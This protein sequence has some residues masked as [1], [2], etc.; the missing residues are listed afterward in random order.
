M[1][2]QGECIHK[3]GWTRIEYRVLF[4]VPRIQHVGLG[5]L[6][7]R[8]SR[9]RHLLHLELA[10]T[11]SSFVSRLL[12]TNQP[13]FHFPRLPAL[14]TLVQYCC[15]IIGQHT[16]PLPTSR[17]YATHHT[18]NNQYWQ[19]QYRVKANF[20]QLPRGSSVSGDCGESIPEGAAGTVAESIP[21]GAA[22]TI[23]ESI[24]EGMAG[25]SIPEGA[26]RLSQYWR[27]YCGWVN[28]GG[29]AIPTLPKEH[30][31]VYYPT[32]NGA[33]FSTFRG[34]AAWTRLRAKG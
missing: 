13:F 9:R 6:R 28:S 18:I 2:I 4:L 23:A 11:R 29:A 1:R 7:R 12:C 25:T 5:P 15:T 24:P 26:L 16:T 32:T 8:I 17:L 27:G 31:Y 21:E 19:W 30:Y 3:T 34:A 14:F 10:F 20:Q 22:G 33:A